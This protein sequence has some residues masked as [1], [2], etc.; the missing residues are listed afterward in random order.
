MRGFAP[1]V[2][3]VFAVVLPSAL[4]QTTPKPP[5]IQTT[6]QCDDDIYCPIV[7]LA[8]CQRAANLL[9]IYDSDITTIVD[10]EIPNLIDDK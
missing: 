1:S 4:A 10:D 2:L 9:Q 5:Y 6:G 3:C 8:G 7:T